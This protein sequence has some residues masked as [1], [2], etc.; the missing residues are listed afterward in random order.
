MIPA[1][2][3]NEQPKVP[4]QL[5]EFSKRYEQQPFIR[6]LVQLIPYGIGSAADTALVTVLNKIRWERARTFFD[7]LA[8]G[9]I[10][11]T[12]EQIANEDFLHAYFATARAA[13]NT[14]RREKIRLF[15]RFFTQYCQGTGF[16]NT[17][18]F[19]EILA[20]LDD[21]TLRELQVLLLLRD[22][23][24]NNPILPGQN[25]MQ[26]AM[27]F[28]SS[29]LHRVEA[30]LD[31]PKAE[32]PGYFGRLNRTGL[33]QTFVGG[34]Y[35]YTGDMGYTTPNFARFSMYRSIWFMQLSPR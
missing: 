34:F 28:W 8:K 13:L 19:E 27:Q 20:V 18:T 9:K 22:F 2:K 4:T 1:K 14:R 17:D 26:R 21:L 32:L 5:E 11:L 12:Q 7:E 10:A 25:A 30:E 6:A 31:I 33:Y 3:E 16:T 29:F 15:G 24:T 35:D 23:E